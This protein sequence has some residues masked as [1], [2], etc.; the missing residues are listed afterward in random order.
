VKNAHDRAPPPRFTN[1]ADDER[2]HADGPREHA[3]VPEH[4]HQAADELA[5][6]RARRGRA[7]AEVGRRRAHSTPVRWYSNRP[8]IHWAKTLVTTPMTS[9]I[10][11]R[12]EQRREL[13]LRRRIEELVREL[14]ADRVG[15]REERGVDP[16]ALPI[17]CVTAIASPS[18]RP[19]PSTTAAVI[20]LRVYGITTPR[21]ISQRVVPSAS[22]PSSSSRGTAKNSSRQMLEMIGTTYD[23]Q[24][25]AGG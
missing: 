9:R 15:R 24:D 14:G 23:R 2:E 4:L 20:P 7:K 19:R 5:A 8:T 22:A 13:E 21:T 1:R 17:T 25:Q 3:P 6:A 10:T 18:A 12:V 16:A 11:A